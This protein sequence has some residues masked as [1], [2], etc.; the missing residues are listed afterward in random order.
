M[1]ELLV[2]EC[3]GCGASSSV[4]DDVDGA[5]LFEE[6]RLFLP[7]HAG[8]SGAATVTLVPQQRQPVGT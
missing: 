3:G 4:P 7:V 1:N 5:A 8:C 2:V 6:L